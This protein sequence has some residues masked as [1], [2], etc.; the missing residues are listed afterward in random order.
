MEELTPGINPDGLRG[1]T[2]SP[3]DGYAS[4]LKTAV[5]YHQLAMRAGVEFR[6]GEKWSAW[7]W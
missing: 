4:P 5:A 7:I 1:G 3:G 6:F 2:Y